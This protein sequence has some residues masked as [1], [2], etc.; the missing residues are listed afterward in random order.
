MKERQLRISEFSLGQKFASW[1][2]KKSLANCLKSFEQLDLHLVVK[3][4]WV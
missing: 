3:M 4:Q 1:E 2:P